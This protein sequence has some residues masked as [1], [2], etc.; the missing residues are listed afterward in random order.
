MWDTDRQTDKHIAW[1]T[2]THEDELSIWQ[3][4]KQTSRTLDDKT[5]KLI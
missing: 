1:Q 3:V 5:S 4:I 2:E